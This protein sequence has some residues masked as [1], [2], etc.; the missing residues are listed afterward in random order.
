MKQ[1]AQRIFRHT[2]AAI[3]VP[4][5]LARKLAPN[6]YRISVGEISIDLSQYKEIVAV[7]FGKAAFVMANALTEILP[8]ECQIEGILVV[9]SPPKDDLARWT[10]FVGGHPVPNLQSFE[11]GRAILQ[12]LARCNEQTLIFFLISGGGSSLVEQPLDA[13]VGLED[14]RRLTSVLVNCGAPIEE[15]NAVR[16]HLSTTKGGRLAAAAP[17]SMKIT[18]AIS[19]VPEGEE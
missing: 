8:P 12:R 19:D 11:A 4:A 18:F 13:G 7:A 14:F 9:P 15:I 2:L 10:T 3:D 17:R 6:D 1:T 5:T 16:K